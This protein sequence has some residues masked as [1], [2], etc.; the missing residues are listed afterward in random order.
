MAQAIIWVID[1]SSII[2]VRRQE[3]LAK[4]KVFAGLGALVQAGRLVYPR[5]VVA[6]LERS[7]DTRSP[8]EQFKW[9]KIHETKACELA[10]TLGQVK[11]VLQDV[12]RVLDADKDTGAE[13]A[14]PYV[15]A[16]ARRLMAEGNHVR[17]VTEEKRDTPRK[18]SLSTAAGLLGLP[19]VPLRAFLDFEEIDP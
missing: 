17:I 3:N 15:L 18:M 19:C 13:E 6:E 9:A 12:P 16:M 8:D 4:P 14:D 10:P 2:E 1:T 11:E 7:V 5:E